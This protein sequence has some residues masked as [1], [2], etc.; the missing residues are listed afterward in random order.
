MRKRITSAIVFSLAA[1]IGLSLAGQLWVSSETAD[2]RRF[3][4]LADDAV[5]R[6]DAKLASYLSL[7][8]ATRAFLA[9]DGPGIS[10]ETFERFISGLDLAERHDGIQGIGFAAT[11]PAAAAPSVADE[12]SARYG[13]TVEIWPPT[14]DQPVR[15]PII[16]L[17]PQDQRNQVALGYD[18]YSDP[19][20]RQ[21]MDAAATTGRPAA[22]GPV[23]LVQEID[24]NRQF[25]FLIYL[26]VAAG[27]AS[28]ASVVSPP[29]EPGFVYA[30]L[31]IGDFLEAALFQKPQPAIH[32]EVFDGEA[33]PENLILASREPL[34]PEIAHFAVERELDVAGRQ[35][36]FRLSPT[37]NFERLGSNYP[38]ALLAIFV[39]VLAIV[40]AL[41]SLVQ[42]RRLEAVAALNEASERN[43]AQK[44][45]LLREMNHRIKNSIARML[46]IAR[47]TARRAESL[48][49]FTA[50]YSARLQA[51]AAAQ[52]MLTRSRW[53]SAQIGALLSAELTQ[54]F[55]EDEESCRLQGPEVEVDET[56]S[57]ALGLTFHELATNAMKYGAL[58]SP[59]GMLVVEWR[60][61][62]KDLVIDWQEQGGQAPDLS[63]ERAGFGTRLIDMT[64]RGELGGSIERR[65]GEGRLAILIRFPFA[66]RGKPQPVPGS[67]L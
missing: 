25:G 66:E 48:E 3:S 20:R 41:L 27:D 42:S 54:V 45:M 12:L 56:V 64:I 67:R 46:S 31:R 11:I 44:D 35:L 51:M 39:L 21:A 55:G 50:R 10:A 16:L 24:E 18:M 1:A 36:L 23:R 47:Q 52:E 38:A 43:L 19:V 32:V 60:L 53:G 29:A 65:A 40:L 9:A 63:V 5:D 4:Q 33:K 62:G 28:A 2:R 30:P 17:E 37:E 13:R 34:L 7:L 14:T 6:V 22:S 49:D 61:D 57:Q 8:Y 59:E 15:T 26:P 58:S